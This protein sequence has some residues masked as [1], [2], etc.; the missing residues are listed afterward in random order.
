MRGKVLPIG[1]GAA[2]VTIGWGI[3]A[4]TADVS[5]E[6]K[7]AIAQ[8]VEDAEARIFERSAVGSDGLS[9]R[10][11]LGKSIFFD[12]A[13]SA[14]KN[15]SCAFCHAPE[16]GFTAPREDTNAAGAVV[17]GSIAGRFGNAKPPTVTY[18]SAAPVLHHRVEDGETLFVGGAF[19][20][21]R[22]TGRELGNPIADQ[23]L[24]P[25]LNPLEMALPDAA[26]VVRRVCHP[27]DPSAYP[28]RLQDLWGHEVC[29]IDWS[30]ELDKLCAD[31][32]VTIAL[33][34]DA[35]E[36]VKGAFEKIGLA[37]AAYE[38]SAEVQPFSSKYDL[39][40]A[41]QVDFTEEEAEG[42]ALYKGK[43]L[44]ANCH[45]L[46]AGPKGEPALFTDFTYDNLGVPR[47]PDNPFYAQSAVFNPEGRS[48]VEV[49]LH[50]TLTQDPLYAALAEANMGKVKVPTLRNVD[51]RPA[52][53]FVKAYMHNG[54]FKSLKTVVHFYNTRDVKPRCNDAMTREADAM[55]LG[56]WPAPEVEANRNTDEMGDLNLSEAEENAIVAFMTTLSDGYKPPADTAPEATAVTPKP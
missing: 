26:C 19:W 14:G 17:E 3:P 35:R 10:A 16:T 23:A 47:N 6:Q 15:Q 48:W 18:M 36:A 12:T 42:L 30:T 50:A 5:S 44:C 28:V 31:P 34:E 4:V 13:L 41:G 7:A 56:C 29:Q 32:D 53:G 40:M 27:D 2:L 37:I 20:N 8:Q 22:A 54:Y 52:P 39:V 9:A 55:R 46:D 51:K 45:V 24:G 43:G 21:G 38:S 25:F 11:R 1:L 33:D 49:G